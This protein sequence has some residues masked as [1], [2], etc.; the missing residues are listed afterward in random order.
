MV[1]LYS[2]WIEPLGRCTQSGTSGLALAPAVWQPSS[3]IPS[4]PIPSSPIPSAPSTGVWGRRHESSLTG[5][6]SWRCD[7]TLLLELLQHLLHCICTHGRLGHLDVL[8]RR[9][10]HAR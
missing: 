4:S 3:P 9:V 6:P 7:D 1:R 8:F 10:D 5:R 2:S